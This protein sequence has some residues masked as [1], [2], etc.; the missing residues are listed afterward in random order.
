MKI[1]T[2]CLFIALTL[3][4]ANCSRLTVKPAT[5]VTEASFEGG[6][7]YAL[8]M[9][10]LTVEIP[11]TEIVRTFAEGNCF[12]A[13]LTKNRL[14]IADASGLKGTKVTFYKLG[15]ITIGGR[16]VAD[17][18]KVFF[19]DQPGNWRKNQSLNLV[20][21]EFG[22]LSKA[23]VVVE[24]KTFD[25]VVQG[26]QGVAG[27]IST[28]AGFKGSTGSPTDNAET[29]RI[30]GLTCK[31]R[32]NEQIAKIESARFG[33]LQASG[34]GASAMSESALKLRLGAFED[35]EKQ[36]VD[37][38]TYTEERTTYLV[39]RDIAIR[40]AA[41]ITDLTTKPLFKFSRTAGLTLWVA[42]TTKFADYETAYLP[43]I[44]T[45]TQTPLTAE[46]DKK[47]YTLFIA[48]KPNPTV[49]VSAG[50]LN[51]ATYVGGL[52]Y[53]LPVM[54]VAR[55]KTDSKTVAVA[56][57]FM[58]QLGRLGYLA[59]R[60]ATASFELN[61]WGGLKTFT[62]KT[63]AITGEQV[64]AA[65]AATGSVA[66]LFKKDAP[67]TELQQLTD[68]RTV[69]DEQIKIFKNSLLLDSLR[70]RSPTPSANN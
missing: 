1:L 4:L 20:M 30:A 57:I 65:S 33:L 32:I 36:L 12:D 21:N 39:R 3:A 43:H 26:V 66:G 46:T 24:D 63:N 48:H 10:M 15:Q 5:A 9:A 2:S 44:A 52:V 23:D 29:V 55:I 6:A 45:I 25:I 69:Q 17:P 56:N 31:E 8:P 59:D 67:K 42:D 18:D 37:E 70:R 40:N 51:A 7:Y 14:G 11:V 34:S 27:I 13:D 53:N 64:A 62:Q 60:S 47:I 35:L 22:V 41:D 19:V 58:P 50:K 38:I 61:E 49:G 54:A 68:Q 16:P 28:L